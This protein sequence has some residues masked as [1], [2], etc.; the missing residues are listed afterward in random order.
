MDKNTGE[1]DHSD[2]AQIKEALDYIRKNFTPS[3]R[4]EAIKYMVEHTD[5]VNEALAEKMIDSFLN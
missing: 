5:R 2:T 1:G 4:E 3:Q